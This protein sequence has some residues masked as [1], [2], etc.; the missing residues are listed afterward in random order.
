MHKSSLEKMA[1]FLERYYPG[2]G[3]ARKALDFGS[4]DL[5]GSY[6]SLFSSD[7]WEYQGLDLEPG[8]NVD[9]VPGDPYQWNEV[10]DDS[11][12]LVLS[13]Q[14]LEHVEFPWLVFETIRRILK[15]NGLCCVIA[16]SAGPEHRHPLDCWRFYPDGMRALCKHAG[17]ACV[18]VATDWE[19]K[20]YA[21]GSE[22]WKDTLL[23][24]RNEVFEPIEALEST[25]P[26]KFTPRYASSITGWHPH[27]DFGYELM[28]QFKP[29]LFVELG[30]HYGDSYFTLCQARE[31]HGLDTLCY[32]IDSWTGDEQSGKYGEEVHQAVV[33]HNQEHYEEFSHLLRTTFDE[34][35]SRFPDDCID[36]LHLDGSHDYDTISRD[37]QSWLPKVKTGGLILIHDV[38]VQR[39]D[40]GVGRLWGEI[41]KSYPYHL[42]EEGFGLGVMVKRS[43]KGKKKQLGGLVFE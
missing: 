15:P 8:D 12:D 4:K 40:F 5:N 38:L 42:H 28:G 43:R 7:D 21:D 10:A 2:D 35:T 20:A 30:V 11:I 32:G 1:A 31:E 25:P 9:L 16:P 17:L 27:R 23:V 34:A 14:A 6:R 24:A 36:L 29:K 26:E 41:T 18:E 39:M 13:G 33:R 19:P 37:F 22:Q 3:I